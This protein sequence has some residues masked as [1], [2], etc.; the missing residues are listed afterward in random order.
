MAPESA[1]ALGHDHD[2]AELNPIAED[3]GHLD[4][5]ARRIGLALFRNSLDPNRFYDR[6]TM[7]EAVI[8]PVDVVKAEQ[9]ITTCDRFLEQV[10]VI[11]VCGLADR[12]LK[13]VPTVDREIC[14]TA[15]RACLRAPRN[16]AEYT[17]FR[18]QL[19]AGAIFA[20]LRWPEPLDEVL[21][22]N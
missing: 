12:H 8:T 18:F 21:I 2:I 16:S 22:R 13:D 5:P 3:K 6:L 15:A 9:R 10:S 7:G 1:V 19:E 4:T 11:G 14:V 20:P 17:L